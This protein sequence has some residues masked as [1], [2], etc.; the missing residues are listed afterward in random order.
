MPGRFLDPQVLY[1]LFPSAGFVPAPSFLCPG[2]ALAYMGAERG[3]G[4]EVAAPHDAAAQ[5]CLI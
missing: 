2:V 1:Y 3:E 4:I 5:V